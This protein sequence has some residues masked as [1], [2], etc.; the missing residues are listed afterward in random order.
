VHATFDDG[1]HPP[2][3]RATDTG[4]AVLTKGGDRPPRG[5]WHGFGIVPRTVSAIYRH[6]LNK[7][8]PA[9]GQHPSL[10]RWHGCGTGRSLVHHPYVGSREDADTPEVPLGHRPARSTLDVH[11]ECLFLNLGEAAPGWRFVIFGQG[12]VPSGR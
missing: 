6:D 8:T 7:H 10:A 5:Y 11:S 4:F 12:G 3:S 2:S 9:C 1:V